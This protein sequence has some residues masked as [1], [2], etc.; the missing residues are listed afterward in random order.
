MGRTWAPRWAMALEVA[1]FPSYPRRAPGAV[2][3]KIPAA[4]GAFPGPC[5]L[6]S[7]PSSSPWALTETGETAGRQGG[8][9]RGRRYGRPSDELK[10][11]RP[12]PTPSGLANDRRWLRWGGGR[13]CRAGTR[14]MHKSPS[15]RACVGRAPPVAPPCLGEAWRGAEEARGRAFP[16]FAPP[17]ALDKRVQ[18]EG[19]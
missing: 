12:P 8:V 1:C 6:G 14:G 17:P 13:S 3:W 10:A 9:W 11:L 18:G 5:I 4:Y 16:R 2:R 19:A 15:V 7:Q